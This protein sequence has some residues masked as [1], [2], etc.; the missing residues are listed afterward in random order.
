M[1]KNTNLSG[2]LFSKTPL[3]IKE[4]A[5]SASIAQWLTLKGFYND[6]LNSGLAFRGKYPVYLCKKGTPD[7]FAIVRGRIVFIEVKQL[8]KE[9]SA[10]QLKRHD[11]L[12]RAGAVVLTVDSFPDFEGKF[13]SAIENL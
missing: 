5:L 13:K 7:R 2:G 12:R 3:T 8:G 6:R 4:N 10:D 9:P 1:P 11:E